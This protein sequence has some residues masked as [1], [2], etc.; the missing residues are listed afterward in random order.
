[1]EL[2]KVLAR[3]LK[4][5]VEDPNRLNEGLLDAYMLLFDEYQNFFRNHKIDIPPEEKK[6]EAKEKDDKVESSNTDAEKEGEA[7][8]TN[9]EKD[10]EGQNDQEMSHEPENLGESG[11]TSNV[12]EA[13][14]TLMSDSIEDME[15][16]NPE[17]TVQDANLL[18]MDD[19]NNADTEGWPE[20]TREDPMGVGN[21]YSYPRAKNEDNKF[22]P[23]PEYEYGFDEELH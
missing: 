5:E 22:V 11:A 1:M 8:Q 23:D 7:D 21:Q 16:Q 12:A 4:Y 18:E 10:D 19:G 13:D 3:Y 20:D 15:N 17:I 14:G 2:L 6:E 9:K